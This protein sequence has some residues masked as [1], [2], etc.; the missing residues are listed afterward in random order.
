MTCPESKSV[1]VPPH[2]IPDDWLE[3]MN[4]FRQEFREEAPGVSYNISV[5]TSLEQV[6][7]QLA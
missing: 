7:S 1:R 2:R 4:T 6:L 3:P 5:R